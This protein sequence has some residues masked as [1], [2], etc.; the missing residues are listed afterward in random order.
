MTSSQT[1]SGHEDVAAAIQN[2][3]NT[4]ELPHKQEETDEEGH[5]V[6]ENDV[7][8]FDFGTASPAVEEPPSKLTS[9]TILYIKDFRGAN[10]LQPRHESFSNAADVKAHL[11]ATTNLW[12][13]SGKHT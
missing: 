5:T 12:L 11:R 13:T 7:L 6:D 4:H 10:H 9:L 8:T 1:G 2:S 3:T